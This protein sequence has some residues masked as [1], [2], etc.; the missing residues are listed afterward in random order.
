M[1][2]ILG[3][4][5]LLVVVC[6][7]GLF[8]VEEGFDNVGGKTPA[9][10]YGSI[11]AQMGPGY[12]PPATTGATVTN[13]PS[14]PDQSYYNYLK[15]KLDKM[16]IKM[17]PDAAAPTATAATTGTA[18][19]TAATP[20]LSPEVLAILAELAKAS[21]TPTVS[22]SVSDSGSQSSSATS[23]SNAKPVPD[24]SSSDQSSP[25]SANQ[26][27]ATNTPALTQGQAFTI[28]VV[29]GTAPTSSITNVSSLMP[30]GTSSAH[31]SSDDCEG[32]VAVKVNKKPS[33]QCPDMSQYVRKD[34]IPCWGCKL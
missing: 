17:P 9:D 5:C 33:N 30:S 24:G 28:S 26:T 10:Y 19:T 20:S 1:R 3:I 18:A 23:T 27:S 34:S 25:G 15:E 12:V 11:A 32:N 31:D 13:D 8:F 29:P 16:N 6:A 7:I 21:A 2:Y 14:Q 22:S 4:V